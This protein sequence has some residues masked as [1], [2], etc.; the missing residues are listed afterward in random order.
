M[1]GR[2]LAMLQPVVART[3]ETDKE[4]A[5]KAFAKQFNAELDRIGIP[6]GRARVSKVFVLLH[7]DRKKLVSREQVRKWV[8]GVD[9]PDQANLRIACERLQLDWA[10]LQT[11]AE[12]DGHSGLFLELQAAWG[13]LDADSTRRELIRYAHYL[14]AKDGATTPARAE[15]TDS[16]HSEADRA[17]LQ[18]VR[19]F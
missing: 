15:G 4:A 19:R 14:G 10:R 3:K 13:A 18:R 7:K 1:R 12:A 9:I 2:P 8:R 16:D 11:G 6:A 5:R 17:A